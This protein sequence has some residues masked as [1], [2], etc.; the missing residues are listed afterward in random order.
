MSDYSDIVDWVLGY[1]DKSGQADKKLV[2]GVLNGVIND[3]NAQLHDYTMENRDKTIAV[4]ANATEVTMPTTCSHVIEL[5]RYDSGS[6]RMYP[7][8]IEKSEAWFNSAFSGVSSISTAPPT[9]INYWFM[10]DDSALKVRKI[11]L[12]YP[13]TTS[14]TMVVRFY[15]KLS[16]ANMDRLEVQDILR[17]GCVS[18]L[19]KWFKEDQGFALRKYEK[20]L[21]VMKQAV[22]SLKR[23]G[24]IHVRSDIAAHNAVASSLV[25]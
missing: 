10:L 6:D 2:E 3:I 11:R 20:Q 7:K 18:R 12:V 17:N 19:G 9:N 15:E 24:V 21:E 14:F 23:S 5:G 8:Y 13:P 1:A 22:R 4:A 16:S 25:N